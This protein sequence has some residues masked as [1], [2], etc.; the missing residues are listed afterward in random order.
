[1]TGQETSNAA[2]KPR[3]LI[4]EDEALIALTMEDCIREL[5]YACVGPFSEL[6]AAIPVAKSEPLDGA[7][8]DIKLDD[9]VSY[10]LPEILAAR[11]IPFGFA[12]GYP[13][14]ALDP[15]WADRPYM[16]KPFD[17]EDVKRMLRT[18]LPIARPS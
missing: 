10:E 5:G 8:F 12:T 9:D 2:S 17:L 6:T 16:A 18:L 3:I 13:R 15:K 7:I 4:V 14:L 1:M 11:G